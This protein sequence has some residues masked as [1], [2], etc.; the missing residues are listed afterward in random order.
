M[1][2]HIF[3]I[4]E[5]SVYLEKLIA[6]LNKRYEDEVEVEGETKVTVLSRQKMKSADIL[7]VQEEQFQQLDHEMQKKSVI[8]SEKTSMEAF[9]GQPCISKFQRPDLI[10]QELIGYSKQVLE[11]IHID[12]KKQ[13]SI[14][15]GMLV[16]NQ[17][18]GLVP[19]LQNHDGTLV[20]QTQGLISWREFL[21][22]KPSQNQL[23][24]M[25]GKIIEILRGLEEY[26]LEV[27]QVVFEEDRV[28]VNPQTLM[29]MLCYVPKEM[30]NPAF[31]G[32]LKGLGMMLA[33]DEKW[34][35]NQLQNGQSFGV[36]QANMEAI[37]GFSQTVLFE[38]DTNN[39]EYGET[40]VFWELQEKARESKERK[41]EAKRR[42]ISLKEMQ[43]LRAY[44]IRRKTG[45]RIQIDTNIFKLGKEKDYVD[46]CIVDNPAISRSHADIVR[47]GEQF[48]IVDQN[49]LNHT[50]IN[51][52]ELV[53]KQTIALQTGTEIRLADEIFEFKIND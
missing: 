26:M 27:S 9:K 44:L 18:E 51:G 3:V 15:V 52:V 25:I 53:P 29:P 6:Y 13:L 43:Q 2:R 28:Y 21:Q 24:E 46:Y 50:F 19:V 11:E 42:G 35:S 49:S 39:D 30:E 22:H 8:L 37:P 31:W 12:E 14:E 34:E 1:K 23:L 17:I 33:G 4:E 38:Q 20:Y 48:F 16:H 5:D 45:E 7:L 47:Q 32:G 36:K 40:E 41:N 10:Y